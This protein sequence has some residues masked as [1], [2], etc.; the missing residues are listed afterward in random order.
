[1]KSALIT[2]FTPF[3]RAN[4]VVFL[5]GFGL[6]MILTSVL[7]SATMMLF[8]TGLL[9]RP[10]AGLAFVAPY[11]LASF[12]PSI[13]VIFCLFVN[14]LHDIGR[15]GIWVLIPALLPLLGMGFLTGFSGEG[16]N[17]GVG[18]AIFTAPILYAGAGVLLLCFKGDPAPNQF[19]ARPGFANG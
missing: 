16:F 2:F 14:R 10:D 5:A 6:L 11:T 8:Q 19:G 4:R 13:W 3:G 17:W 7:S 1:M 15:T 18:I 9:P 12:L